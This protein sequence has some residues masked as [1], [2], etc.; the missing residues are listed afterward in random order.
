MNLAISLDCANGSYS[1]DWYPLRVGIF[2][3]YHML[4]Q[5]MEGLN[6]TALLREG[7]LRDVVFPLSFSTLSPSSVLMLTKWRTLAE[8]PH[9]HARCP[10]VEIIEDKIQV[11]LANVVRDQL[12][13]HHIVT[14]S[15]DESRWQLP[16][17]VKQKD[18]RILYRRTKDETCEGT[19]TM[20]LL[21]M[22]APRNPFTRILKRECF[23]IGSCQ[24]EL[25]RQSHN[26][27]S[28]CVGRVST[29]INA[30]MEIK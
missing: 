3:L 1:F 21:F 27:K 24:F 28:F 11:V 15:S 17:G 10:T 25:K 20:N 2:D 22:W 12:Q 29:A 9:E 23:P 13:F 4:D 16:R 26:S 19:R 18:Y 14:V 6:N 8:T 5:T 7:L 30:K